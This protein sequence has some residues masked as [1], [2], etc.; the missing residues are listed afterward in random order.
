MEKNPENLM[1]AMGYF[2]F[3]YMEQ[4]KKEKYEFS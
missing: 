4:L 3:F 1:K 2:E